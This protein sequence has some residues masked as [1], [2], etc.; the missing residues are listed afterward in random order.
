[1]PV[2]E[3]A[4]LHAAAEELFV[5]AAGEVLGGRAVAVVGGEAALLLDDPGLVVGPIQPEAQRLLVHPQRHRRG[6]EPD[7]AAGVGDLRCDAGLVGPDD[8]VILVDE[9]APRCHPDPE[10]VV[11]EEDDPRLRR[12]GGDLDGAALQLE[13]GHRPDGRPLCHGA[14]R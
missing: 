8:H 10:H 7:V 4:V 2:G 6:G 5:S 13:P 12:P 1:V 9:A 14:R 11:G 3:A